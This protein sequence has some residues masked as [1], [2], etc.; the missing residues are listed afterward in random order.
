MKRIDQNDDFFQDNVARQDRVVLDCGNHA[1]RISDSAHLKHKLLRL[2]RFLFPT[3]IIADP[4]QECFHFCLLVTTNASACNNIQ[5]TRASQQ[6]VINR[7]RGDLVH[8]YIRGVIGT[9]KKLM[10]Q[11]C[12]FTCSQKPP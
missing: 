4:M 12:A 9:D 6:R 3:A 10:P 11:P 7:M 2:R 5:R 8:Q 1:T